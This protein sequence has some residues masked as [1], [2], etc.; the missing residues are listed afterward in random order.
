LNKQKDHDETHLK[1][2]RKVK[3]EDVERGKKKR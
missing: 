1:I 3:R 2:A